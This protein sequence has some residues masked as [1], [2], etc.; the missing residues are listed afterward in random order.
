MKVGGGVAVP[1]WQDSLN[2]QVQDHTGTEGKG[3]GVSVWQWMDQKLTV[4]K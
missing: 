3:K 2:S 1:K 4:L